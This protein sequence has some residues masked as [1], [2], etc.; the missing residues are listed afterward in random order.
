MNSDACKSQRGST[1]LDCQLQHEPGILISFVGIRRIMSRS[2]ARLLTILCLV[3]SVAIASAQLITPPAAKFADTKFDPNPW[4]GKWT[5]YDALFDIG[6]QGRTNSDYLPRWILAVGNPQ[7]DISFRFSQSKDGAFSFHINRFSKDLWIAVYVDGVSKGTVYAAKGSADYKTLNSEFAVAVPSGTH[8]VRLVNLSA[9]DFESDWYRVAGLRGTN[10]HYSVT[11]AQRLRITLRDWSIPISPASGWM[12]FTGSAMPDITQGQSTVGLSVNGHPEFSPILSSQFSTVGEKV[13]MI[14]IPTATGSMVNRIDATAVYNVTLGK[15]DLV[16]GSPTTLPVPL[17]TAEVSRYST[18]DPIFNFKDPVVVKWINDKGLWLKPGEDLLEFAFRV[19]AAMMV[20]FTYTATNGD[21]ASNVIK[22]KAGGCGALD[23]V[24]ASAMRANSIEARVTTGRYINPDPSDGTVYYHCV[25][26]FFDQRNGWICADVAS[27]VAYKIPYDSIGKSDG[28]YFAICLG[29]IYMGLYPASTQGVTF[30]PTNQNWPT[31][32][33]TST[34]LERLDLID[35]DVSDFTVASSSVSGGS[36]VRATI[37]LAMNAI[38]SNGSTITLTSDTNLISL[39]SSI[40]IPPGSNSVEFNIVTT[41]VSS[42]VTAHLVAKG[43]T[44]SVKASLLV[45]APSVST[46]FVNPS[47]VVGGSTTTVTGTVSIGSVA[48]AGGIV[49]VLASNQSSV[50]VPANV[51]IAAG[52]TSASFAVKTDAVAAPVSAT[53]KGTLGTSLS[54]VLAVNPPV[55]SKITLSP[56][57]LVGGSSS[58]AT[59]TIDNPAPVGGIAVALTSSSANAKVPASVSVA[60]G[61][62][63]A[64]FV[65]T[66]SGV[67]T[68]T[69]AT[70]SAKLGVTTTTGLSIQPALLSGFSVSPTSLVGGNSPTCTISLSG[71]APAGG[72]IV[73]LTTTDPMVKVPATLTVPAG[74]TSVSVSLST[75]GVDAKITATLT[76]KYG[77]VSK[78]CTETLLTAWLVGLDVN[79][80]TVVGGS[81]ATVTGKVNLNGRAGPS[82]IVAQLTSSNSKVLTVPSSVKI[83]ATAINTSFTVKTTKVTSTQKVTI[84]ATSGAISVTTTVTVNPS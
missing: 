58:T 19:Q 21:S 65:I 1:D 33:E 9:G 52:A 77:T 41:A 61:A 27:P 48:P 2:V 32:G 83:G 28:G 71:Q 15:C 49:V 59:I 78:S 3:A 43:G 44:S 74:A 57:S 56:T 69:T 76:A 75:V 46:I 13:Q 79:P 72:A 24:F 10:V 64:T 16:P 63:S 84:T 23:I 62:K 25:A 35:P 30:L 17:T 67:S 26:Q 8:I 53:I 70:I 6:A 60:A 38:G 66:T 22:A 55:V 73:S 50:T 39:P 5:D 14:Q 4:P 18:D 45:K 42:D 36:T 54:A 81:T 40:K 29:S 34:T 20:D 82:G 80:P 7:S 37:T 68:L 12:L 51:K 47:T 11:P 31:M